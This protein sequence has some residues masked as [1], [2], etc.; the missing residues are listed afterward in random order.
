MLPPYLLAL[1]QPP[2]ASPPTLT[3]SARGRVYPSKAL[4]TALR[5]RAGQPADLLPPS[6]ACPV[7]QLDLRPQARRRISWH[8]NTRPRIESV[9]LPAGLVKPSTPLLLALT[10][11]SPTA[12][13]LYPLTLAAA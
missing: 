9:T 4:L 10:T 13:G 5:L 11:T 6:P 7:W 1:H 12:P 2:L 3:V 8:A